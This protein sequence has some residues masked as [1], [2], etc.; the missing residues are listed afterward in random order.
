MARP[1]EFVEAQVVATAR[2]AFWANG[3][4]GTSISDLSEATGLSVGSIYK[5]FRSKS[6]L[7]HATL[8]DYLQK[9]RELMAAVL[10]SSDRAI[11][12]LEAWLEGHAQ[13]SGEGGPTSGCYAVA[14]T[15]EVV[16]TDET[17]TRLLREHDE[18]VRRLIG[19]AIADAVAQGDLRADPTM[20]ARMLLAVANGVAVDARK[21]IT[22]EEARA[23]LALALDALR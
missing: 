14:C 15:N 13:V 19:R 21:G 5:A 1:R 4:A 17:A 7:F 22:T 6:G 2:D 18:A 9:G 3:V 11:E 12:G 8:E 10:G 23:A 16:P 20:G